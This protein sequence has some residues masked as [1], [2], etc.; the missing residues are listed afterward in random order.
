MTGAGSRLGAAPVGYVAGLAPVGVGAVLYL[1]LWNNGS[2]SRLRICS[3][4]ETLLGPA[5]GANA[6]RSFETLCDICVRYGRRPLALHHVACKCLGADES[7]FANFIEY[8][9]EGEREDACLIA[10][11]IVRPDMAMTLAGIAEEFGLALRCMCARAGRL[12]EFPT[13]LH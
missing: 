12:P 6:F 5:Q 10:T 3:D 2:K 4:F 11:T 13:T 1:R 8:A 9:S 7:C